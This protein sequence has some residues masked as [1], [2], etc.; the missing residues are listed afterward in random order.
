MK[1]KRFNPGNTRTI[2]IGKP[3]IRFAKQG[4]ITLASTLTKKI[5]LK[6]NDSIEFIQDEENPRDWYLKK[7][8]KEKGFS[9]RT[10]NK[11]T[12]ALITNSIVMVNKFL[13]S[14]D[15]K[16]A[17]SVGCLVATEPTE[18]EGLKLYA[19]ITSSAS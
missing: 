14:I 10:Y 15:K 18:V 11:S 5:G 1:L 4:T 13:E 16:N 3:T 9:L 7:A 8:Y 17:K 6:E 19:I 12:G 2:R